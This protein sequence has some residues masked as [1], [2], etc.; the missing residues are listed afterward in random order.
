M[1]GRHGIS[2]PLMLPKPW[3][4]LLASHK[5][6]HI[7]PVLIKLNRLPVKQRIEFKFALLVYKALNGLSPEYMVDLLVL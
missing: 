7:T 6:A 1:S 4:G 3:H 5:C 2:I